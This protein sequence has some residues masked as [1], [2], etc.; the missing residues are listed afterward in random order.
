V[1]ERLNE[2]AT[3]AQH[4]GK[5]RLV[6][7]SSDAFKAT[8]SR[9]TFAMCKW[10]QFD[11]RVTIRLQYSSTSD[12]ATPQK[13]NPDSITIIGRPIGLVRQGAFAPVKLS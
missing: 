8:R 6:E 5:L 1:F 9:F 13:V 3:L 12:R 11:N 10:S 2:P 7:S 4:D